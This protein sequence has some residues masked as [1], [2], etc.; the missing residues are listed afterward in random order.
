MFILHN[1]GLIGMWVK[2]A[3]KESYIRQLHFMNGSFL[4]NDVSLKVAH[5]DAMY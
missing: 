5:P 2:N 4:F 1:I 3:S